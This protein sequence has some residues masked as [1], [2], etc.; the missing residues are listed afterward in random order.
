MSV[1]PM[2]FYKI[3]IS[4]YIVKYRGM[5]FVPLF[6]EKKNSNL[7]FRGKNRNELI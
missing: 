1:T 5:L 7:Y 6:I 2:Y 3:E 4:K